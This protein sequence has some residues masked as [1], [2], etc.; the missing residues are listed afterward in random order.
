MVRELQSNQELAGVFPVFSFSNE[1]FYIK[2]G[3]LG[4]NASTLGK[5]FASLKNKKKRS[6]P[7]SRKE[8]A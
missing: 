2:L 8:K 1:I 3:M 5:S 4:E 7:G 6:I